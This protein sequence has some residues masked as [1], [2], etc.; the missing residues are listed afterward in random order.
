VTVEGNKAIF[1]AN[2]EKLSEMRG[3]PPAGGG[4]V[5]F[6]LGTSKTDQ[7]TSQFTVANFQIRDLPN[8]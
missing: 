3:I 6:E 7:G 8:P 4:Q 2:G 1:W 5:G